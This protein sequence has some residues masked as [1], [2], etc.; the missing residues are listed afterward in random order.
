MGFAI[1]ALEEFTVVI[2]KGEMKRIKP[3]VIDRK[4]VDSE[5]KPLW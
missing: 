4:R 3:I 5:T 1:L 2:R